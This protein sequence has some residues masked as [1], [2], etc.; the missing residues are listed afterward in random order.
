MSSENE[1]D[2]TLGG[3]SQREARFL[4]RLSQ[5]YEG[6]ESAGLFRSYLIASVMILAF[7]ALSRWIPWW[8]VSLIVVQ[9]LGLLL[10]RQ[11][12]RFAR[13]K[14]RLLRTLWRHVKAS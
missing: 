13:F 12:K 8:W 10:F 5:K 1:N 4:D 6:S 3:V 11:Y 7:F 2:Q 9:I 14:S